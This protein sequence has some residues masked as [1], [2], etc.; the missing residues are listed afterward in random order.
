MKKRRQP[1]SR[2]WN[3]LLLVHL[4]L[5]VCCWVL[6][7]YYLSTLNTSD[8]AFHTYTMGIFVA[9]AWTPLL[10]LHVGIHYYLAGRRSTDEREIYR[11]GFADAMRQF[12]DRSYDA[13]RLSL[14][15]EG[16]LVEFDEKRKRRES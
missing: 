6:A 16:E 12:A 9:L 14:D 11:E 5:Y 4:L 7:L 10:L 3:V 1:E 15:D 13:Q 8:F 2:L